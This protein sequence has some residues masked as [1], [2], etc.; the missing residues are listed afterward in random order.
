MRRPHRCASTEVFRLVP[1]SSLFISASGVINF[2]LGRFRRCG[3]RAENP[4]IADIVAQPQVEYQQLPV[5][6][7]LGW[8]HLV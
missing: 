8:W 3:Q 5:L 2:L 4:G 1:A 7:V 6:Y